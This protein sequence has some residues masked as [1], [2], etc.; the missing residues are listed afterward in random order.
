MN[1]TEL[2][3][4]AG[5][6]TG[7]YYCTKCNT[8]SSPHNPTREAAEQ[9]CQPK[10]CACGKPAE[11]YSTTCHDCRAKKTAEREAQ[12]LQK[13]ERVETIPDDCQLFADDNYCAD[14]DDYLEQTDPE[15]RR[16]YLYLAA[17]RAVQ[18]PN[19]IDLLDSPTDGHHEDIMDTVP[20]LT[21]LNAAIA[22]ANALFIKSKWGSYFQDYTR[23]IRIQSR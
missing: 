17:F 10:L 21:D 19:A 20:D 22:T 13:A 8:I 11:K 14:M 7:V 18:L 5:K 12:R 6:P 2:Y 23:K 3:T 4:K 16:E 9:C 1:A 15:D